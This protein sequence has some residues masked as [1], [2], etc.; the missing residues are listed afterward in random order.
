MKKIFLIFILIFLSVS[1][2][3][4]SNNDKPEII[5]KNSIDKIINLIKNPKY[6]DDSKKNIQR[7]EIWSVVQNI[8]DFT[9]MSKRALGK[10]CRKLKDNE[11]NEFSDLFAKFLANI[12][13]SKFD[14]YSKDSE[15]DKYSAE[16]V[17]YIETTIPQANKAIVKTLL[18]TGTNEIPMDYSMLN[19]NGWRIYDVNIEGVSL[20]RNYRTQFNSLI[21][22]KG[23]KGL[24][25]MIKNK[26]GKFGD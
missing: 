12:Y 2:T 4:Y 5:L 10:N 17:K 25:E 18:V 23:F 6:K 11:I 1:S 15:L 20:V 22:K 26:L 16:S 19:N 3:A 14:Q 9:E 24:I 13:Y 8:F 7:K 21:S